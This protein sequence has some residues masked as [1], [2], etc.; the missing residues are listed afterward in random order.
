MASAKLLRERARQ[1]R[2]DRPG[3]VELKI[4]SFREARRQALVSRGDVCW[5]ARLDRM[6]RT[7]QTLA[8][9]LRAEDVTAEDLT[10]P[11]ADGASL[12][13]DYLLSERERKGL[14]REWKTSRPSQKG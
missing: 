13:W 4:K 14:W 7:G 6:A 12:P 1:L 5:G 11:V 3:G 2:A 9:V 10:G 8:D